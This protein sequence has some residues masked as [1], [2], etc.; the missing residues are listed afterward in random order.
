MK[1][2]P[3]ILLTIA[4]Y[5]ATFDDIFRAITASVIMVSGAT[6]IWATVQLKEMSEKYDIWMNNF[7]VNRAIN[8]KLMQY[9]MFFSFAFATMYLG[10]PNIG[11]VPAATFAVT[12]VTEMRELRRLKRA[13]SA[14]AEAASGTR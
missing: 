13:R 5:G 3:V 10:S 9:L 7:Y 11:C 4:G 14:F 2:E 8:W 12:A 6:H 1:C